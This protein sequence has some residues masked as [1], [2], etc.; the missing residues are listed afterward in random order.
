SMVAIYNEKHS[1][2][3]IDYKK[4]LSTLQAIGLKRIAE[5]NGLSEKD[6]LRLTVTPHISE[7]VYLILK[8]LT[9]RFTK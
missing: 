2:N 5:Q 3:S 9:N 6:N 7:V 1:G 8:G 4:Y